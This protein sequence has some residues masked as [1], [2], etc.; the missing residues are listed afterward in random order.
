MTDI[1]DAALWADEAWRA[2][3]APEP[4]L[5][6]SKW[7]TQH[8]ILSDLSA[9]PGQWRTSR[10]PYLEEIMDCLSACNPVERV[11]LMKGGQLGGTECG[12][13]WIGYCIHHAPGLMLMVMPTLDAIKRNTTARIDPMIA[14]APA[15]AN[16]VVEPRAREP[17][18]SQFKKIFPGGQL[19]MVG[20]TSG[21][22][23]RSTP[24]RY[25]FMDEVDAYPGDAGGDGDPVALAIQRTV[26]F[27]GRRKIFLCSTPTLK[28]FSRI[29]KA[30]QES[31]QRRYQVPCPR[32]GEY[33]V[34]DWSQ[35]QWPE[36]KRHLAYR[37]CPH[38][39]GVAEE[40]EKPAMLA[41]GRWVATVEG[42]GKT[43]GFH[44]S[45]L[46]SPFETWGEIAVE[47]GQVYK[48]PPRLQVWTN[49]KLGETWEDQ[50]G[51]S[52][53]PDSLMAR[54]EHWGQLLPAGVALLTA[55]VDLQGD[56]IEL[57]VVG[58][59]CDEECWI[60]DY[61]V[62]WG[63]PSGPKVWADLDSALH[64]TYAH[65]RAVSD[66]AIR[67]VAVDT[68]G[69]H[70]KAAYEFCRTRLAR[71]VWAIKGRG[72]AAVPVWPRRPTRS[73]KGKIPL[74]IVG[75]DAVKDALFARLKLTESGPGTIHFGFD[76]DA[77]YFRQFTAEKVV[78]R[79]ERGR[80]A[81]SWQLKR[82]GDRNE[83]LDTMVYATAALHGLISMG[84]R[85]NF[86]AA[87][88]LATPEKSGDGKPVVR[89]PIGRRTINSN[90]MA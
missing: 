89:P 29:E 67:A 75:V 68:G 50:A 76:R 64:A 27:R 57:Q 51:E 8:R 35:I 37:V 23:L 81:R 88:M 7:A 58:W 82:E 61:K 47:H 17:G 41:G 44:I 16:L 30:Y 59:G 70:T 33:A 25:L 86:E 74:F 21:V 78:T 45:T 1:L 63:D 24:A 4:T 9:E 12:L 26:T 53:E 13:N 39:Q 54:R 66:L 90:Y 43:A 20:A 22:G 31:D 49:N 18:N 46:Y 56:R 69:H 36:G 77:E 55:G 2:G 40:R 73:N 84:L 32:C 79:Y 5:T 71:R 15:L 72:G 85:L 83:A 62:I 6:V 52:V 48:D 34:I 14:A 38:C 19:V 3:A 80:P 87:A 65:S 60:V 42:D 28:D 11:A 10:V